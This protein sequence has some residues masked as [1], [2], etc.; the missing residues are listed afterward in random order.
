M[1]K[2]IEALVSGR[3]QK[4]MYRDF[5]QRT[6]SVLGIL[7]FV[8]NSEDGTVRIVAEGVE[9]QLKIFIE[10]LRE[11]SLFSKVQDL[12]LAWLPVTGEF[13]DFRIAYKN[14]FDRL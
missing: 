11:G 8:Q 4:V 3:V 7:G 14:F 2:R 9:S 10:K 13:S 6:A 12:S 5:V 1:T